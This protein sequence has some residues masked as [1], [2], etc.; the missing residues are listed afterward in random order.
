MTGH[1]DWMTG[2]FDWENHHPDGERKKKEMRIE[3][4]TLKK[5]A[6]QGAEGLMHFASY[7]NRFQ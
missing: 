2:H 3:E 7:F 6:C 5:Q 4:C 1:F